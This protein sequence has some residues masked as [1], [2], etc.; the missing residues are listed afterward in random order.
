VARAP[1]RAVEAWVAKFRTAAAEGFSL[2]TADLGCRARV[3]RVSELRGPG[4]RRRRRV[5]VHAHACVGRCLAGGD[6][7]VGV[8]TVKMMI[9]MMIGSSKGKMKTKRGRQTNLAGSSSSAIY[10]YI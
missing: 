6:V 5:W 8:G 2:V 9:M 1:R 3:A 7:R 10:L 4:R